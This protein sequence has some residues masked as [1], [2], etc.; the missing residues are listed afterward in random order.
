MISLPALIIAAVALFVIYLIKINRDRPENFPPGPPKLPVYG[1]YWYV[2]KENFQFAHRALDGLAKK[3]KTDILGFYL[4]D[5][6]AVCTFSTELNK[7]LLTKDE[8]YGKAESILTQARGNGK[9]IGIFF[10]DGMYWQDQRRFT[11]RHL[12]DYGFGRRS[13]NF[14][15]F[16]ID[17]IQHMMDLL[18]SD[19]RPEDKDICR[20]K[21]EVLMPD[22]VYGYFNN[23]MWYLLSG[24]SHDLK[25]CRDLSRAAL[26]F[27]RAGDVLGGAISIT[28]WLRHIAPTFFG[29]T[30]AVEDNRKMYVYCE[31]IVKEHM[32]TYD[33]DHHRDFIDD[34]IFEINK[35]E[36]QGIYN[37]SFN[38]EQMTFIV[39]DFMFPAP[40]AMGHT[41][42]FL[43]GYLVNYPEV[44]RKIQEEVDLVVGRGRLPCL[45]DRK[46]MHYTEA[47]IREILRKEPANPLGLTRTST[48]DTT[49]GGYFIPKGTVVMTNVHSAHN[50]P[51]VWGDPE[52]FR[53]ERWIE[54]DGTL[55]KKDQTLGF[56]A[57]KRVCGGETFA[58]H[59][60]FLFLSCLLQN[61][62]FLP[63]KG[64]QKPDLSKRIFGINISLPDFWMY[65]EPRT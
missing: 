47:T 35:L 41:T 10:V 51:K 34:Y 9:R 53:P 54:A 29:Y 50:D 27:Q 43:F 61:F 32:A 62:T 24:R 18:L 59:T 5:T 36:S 42:N 48:A 33:A 2:L 22:I 28:P 38:V 11:L 4:G 25:T 15:Q 19:P 21:G 46:N 14:E 39:M 23:L 20:A 45:D 3:Y 13:E 57:G 17:Q 64:E 58:R 8:F 12:R 16:T 37:T 63:P 44:Q 1:S 56:G 55:T 40:I 31:E 49:L 6:P 65:A 26:G 52:N 7:E 60:M 30:S